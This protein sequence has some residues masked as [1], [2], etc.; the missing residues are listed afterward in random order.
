MADMVSAGQTAPIPRH[1]LALTLFVLLTKH[2]INQDQGTDPAE[3]LPMRLYSKYVE[4]QYER[5]IPSVLVTPQCSRVPL[6]LC[7]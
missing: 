7:Q 1:K 4:R 3:L 2:S 5:N 6:Q